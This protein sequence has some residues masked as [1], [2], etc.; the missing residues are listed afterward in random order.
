VLNPGAGWSTKL[1]PAG[2]F[3][4]LA[5]LLR[6]ELSLDCLVTWHGPAERELAERVAAGGAARLAPA[7]GLPE[8]AELL[9][10]AALYVG[11]DT[12]P[13]H[14]AAA[15]GTPTAAL[16]GAADAARNRPL[17]PHVETLSAGLDCSPCWRRSGC[18]RGVECM[19]Q[20]APEAVL[21]AARR[22][23]EAPR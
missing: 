6:S 14:I 23:L 16:F 5:G 19:G 17:G 11:S 7:T 9:R 8:L 2:H 15:A 22:L 4:R 10:A 1:W 18:P 21:T 3:H 13:T 20:L 12:G